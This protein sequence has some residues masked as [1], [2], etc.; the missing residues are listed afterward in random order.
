MPWSWNINSIHSFNSYYCP[1]LLDFRLQRW[2]GLHELITKNL[3]V[4]I[5]SIKCPWRISMDFYIT[6]TAIMDLSEQHDMF[7]PFKVLFFLLT[8]CVGSL[9][10]A[11]ITALAMTD[12]SKDVTVHK[13]ITLA[14]LMTNLILRDFNKQKFK[15]I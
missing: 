11:Q 3:I 2:C 8:F 13:R 6:I 5:K 10:K 12:T 14:V 7:W 9:H 4:S 15:C 1:Y